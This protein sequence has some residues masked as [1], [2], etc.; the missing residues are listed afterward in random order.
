MIEGPSNAAELTERFGNALYKTARAWRRAVDR[1]LKSTGMGIGR[2]SW[3]TIAAA[4]RS[5]SPMSQSALA[6]M[7][8][9]TDAAMVGMIDCL[10]D[11]GF[12]MRER[13][14]SDRRVKRIV[15]TDA[16]HRIY[17][18]LSNEVAAAR[19]QLLAPIG[20]AELA[21]LTALLELLQSRLDSYH[22]GASR[23]AGPMLI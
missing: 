12:V 19:E 1:R 7:L 3:M 21:H 20:W 10:V 17:T 15:M 9:V 6:D 14:K 2:I 8:L 11:A 18:E 4:A 5:S 16:G 13:S 22:T 23:S